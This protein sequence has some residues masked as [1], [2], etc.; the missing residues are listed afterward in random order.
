[1]INA[2]L[3]DIV[4]EILQ[5]TIQVTQVIG[6]AGATLGQVDD[7][8]LMTLLQGVKTLVTDIGD[9]LQSDISSLP[10]GISGAH[11]SLALY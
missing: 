9:S 10:P 4:K 11:P 3:S 1:M 2:K 7:G 5:A 8:S 6:S